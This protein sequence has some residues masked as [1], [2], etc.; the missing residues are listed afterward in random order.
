LVG[1]PSARAGKPIDAMVAHA[2][3]DYRQ[4]AGEQGVPLFIGFSPDNP[5]ITVTVGPRA[6]ATSNECGSSPMI[7]LPDKPWVKCATMA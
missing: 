3:D 1:A 6:A 2:L 7:G 5:V 4:A